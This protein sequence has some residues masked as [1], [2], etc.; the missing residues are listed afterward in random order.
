MYMNILMYIFKLNIL[1]YK[2]NILINNTT[3]IKFLNVKLYRI[4]NSN[5]NYEMPRNT[6]NKNFARFMQINSKIYLKGFVLVSCG[7]SHKLPQTDQ[8]GSF[9]ETLRKILSHPSLLASGCYW[10][11]LS[12][13]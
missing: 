5:K 10:H 6:F 12:P 2:I 8:V 9:T 1:I 4:H 7:C 11:I 3:I 13:P